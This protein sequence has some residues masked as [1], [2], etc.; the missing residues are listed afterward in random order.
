MCVLYI[1]YILHIY[2]LSKS[3][4]A[5]VC[6]LTL[7]VYLYISIYMYIYIYIY[8]YIYVYLS[9]VTSVVLYSLARATLMSPGQDLKMKTACKF[10]V[11]R[12]KMSRKNQKSRCMW[13]PQKNKSHMLIH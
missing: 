12:V 9:L 1:I 4:T 7:Y 3:E 2:K 13:V 11:F 5:I 8:V 10:K 6:R